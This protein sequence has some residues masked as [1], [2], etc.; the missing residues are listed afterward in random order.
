MNTYRKSMGW[1]LLG[2]LLAALETWGADSV[3]TTA[4]DQGGL[5]WFECGGFPKGC[6]GAWVWGDSEKAQSGFYVRAPKGYV[7]PSHIHTSP[8]R[9]LVLR[10]RM[11][12]AVDGGAET[13]VTPGMY[14]GFAGKA[15]HWA[16]CEDDCLMYIT[17]DLPFDVTFR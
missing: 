16:R 1:V 6:E 11:S 5:K 7:F 4:P 14:W 3:V 12:G 2:V 9:I 8:E 13:I 17:Y 15:V 10:G